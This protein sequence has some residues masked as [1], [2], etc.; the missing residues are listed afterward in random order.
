[1]KKLLRKKERLLLLVVIGLVLV[2]MP[3]SGKAAEWPEKKV[4][5]KII[6]G[7]E[8]SFGYAATT[9]LAKIL[10][11]NIKNFAAYPQA[12][13]TI[14]GFRQMAKGE[15]MMTYG[16]TA[17]LEQAY[18]GKGPF[19]KQPLKGMKPQIGLPILPFTF[20]MVAKKDSGIYT[21]DDLA[22]RRITIST[23]AYGI[24]TPARD[25]MEALGL[26]GKVKHKDVSFADYAGA[27]AGGIVDSIMIYIISDSTTSGAIRNVEARIDMRVLTFTEDQKRVIN[28][29]PGIGFRYAKNIFPEL[30]KK[31]IGGW[32][33]FY[34]WFFSPRANNEL[35]YEI[36][37]ICYEKREELAKALIGF[38]P[39][40]TDPKGLLK[41]GFSI[42]PDVPH[43]PGAIK[44]FKEIKVE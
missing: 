34:G 43:H 24:Y 11:D 28:R 9:V 12:G 36:T 39:W 22:G 35:V 17:S 38:M 26:W 19:A 7:P 5:W 6:C 31:T 10:T 30:K 8:G 1:M 16:N 40:K 15:L 21:M 37:K 2:L 18:L 23:P 3:V 4:E 14:K 41:V 25:V 42:T 13:G 44:F 29:L 32:S 20:F 33:Y 27:I